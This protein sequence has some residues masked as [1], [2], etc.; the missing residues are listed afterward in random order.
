MICYLYV[1]W[2]TGRPRLSENLAIHRVGPDPGQ[3]T[4]FST[5]T[6]YVFFFQ[7]LLF[8]ESVFTYVLDCTRTLASFFM[9]LF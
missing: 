9:S 1:D 3:H 8:V 2:D 7:G 6:V 4:S 5:T